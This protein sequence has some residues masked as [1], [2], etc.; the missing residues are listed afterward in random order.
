MA[1]AAVPA[2]QGEGGAVVMAKSLP[3]LI[4]QTNRIPVTSC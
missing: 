3:A 4:K 2:D 1:L